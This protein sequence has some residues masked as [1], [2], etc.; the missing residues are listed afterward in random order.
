MLSNH[1]MIYVYQSIESYK[2]WIR[3]DGRWTMWSRWISLWNASENRKKM[4]IFWFGMMITQIVNITG[5]LYDVLWCVLWCLSCFYVFY[6]VYDVIYDIFL[7]LM[8]CFYVFY[9][10]IYDVCFYSP[11]CCMRVFPQGSIQGTKRHLKFNVCIRKVR[12]L[13]CVSSFYD[14]FCDAFHHIMMWFVIFVTWFV[15]CSIM[16]WCVSSYYDVIY[17]V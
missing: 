8:M 6:D 14:V 5:I 1:Y 4:K 12:Y 16:L 9:D 7:M 2:H 11:A 17:D 10:V 3:G 13:W 15:M